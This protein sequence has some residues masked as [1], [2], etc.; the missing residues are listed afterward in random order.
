MRLADR[1]APMRG[2]LSE[3]SPKPSSATRPAST[4]N[5]RRRL[6]QKAQFGS[7]LSDPPAVDH[8]PEDQP[9]RRLVRRL[10][11]DEA[12]FVRPLFARTPPSRPVTILDLTSRGA[13]VSV[14][15][16]QWLTPGRLVE[17]G[18]SGVWS[19]ARVV[20]SQPT[21]DGGVVAGVHF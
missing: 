2:E 6:G 20:W 10:P 15:P 11:I 17:L 3:A 4:W 21:S 5:V 9:D 1:T 12:A 14:P 18:V 7:L 19:P 13:S 8:L 16:G